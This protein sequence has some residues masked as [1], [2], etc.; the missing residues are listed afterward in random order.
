[1]TINILI[2]IW[3]IRLRSDGSVQ[4]ISGP[5]PWT[6]ERLANWYRG[7]LPWHNANT[8]DTTSTI[9]DAWKR[10]ELPRPRRKP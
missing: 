1:M 8:R 10:G 6:P 9:A 7:R 4:F 5:G 3:V 2:W